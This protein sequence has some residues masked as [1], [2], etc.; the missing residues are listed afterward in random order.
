M[1]LTGT[2]QDVRGVKVNTKYGEKDMYWIA[3]S[4]G[5]DYS[6]FKEPLAAEATRAKNL[7]G[8]TINVSQSGEFWNFEGVVSLN[9]NN[10]NESAKVIDIP[11][12]DSKP[13]QDRSREIHR[14]TAGKVAASLLSG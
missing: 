11:V 9:G 8:V 5:R 3:F 1:E 2:I 7:D 6:T 4:D 10:P 12:S 14:Q 13:R